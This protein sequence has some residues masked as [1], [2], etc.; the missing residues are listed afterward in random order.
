[1][2]CLSKKVYWKVKL[3]QIEAYHAS[4]CPNP[5]ILKSELVAPVHVAPKQKHIR[6]QELSNNL[7]CAAREDTSIIIPYH[8]TES[9]KDRDVI[10]SVDKC[11]Y[12]PNLSVSLKRAE[13]FKF[14]ETIY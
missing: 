7:C 11:G 8:V 12:A 4:S 1:M 6:F 14:L 10:L 5:G 3:T 2:R 13:I 9:S